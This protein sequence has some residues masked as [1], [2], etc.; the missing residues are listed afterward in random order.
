MTLTAV[1]DTRGAREKVETFDSVTIWGRRW[2]FR[3]VDAFNHETLAPSEGYNSAY[4]RDKTANR[5]AR[6][7]GCPIVE[8]KRK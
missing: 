7:L 6:G 8:G 3:I 5:L 4:A 1:E 2:Y